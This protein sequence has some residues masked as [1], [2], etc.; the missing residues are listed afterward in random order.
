MEEKVSY[1]GKAGEWISAPLNW[2]GVIHAAR[3]GRQIMAE[4][5]Y[6]FIVTLPNSDRQP[7]KAVDCCLDTGCLI[8]ED[9]EGITVAAYAAGHWVRVQRVEEAAEEEV[10]IDCR[11]YHQ[12][13]KIARMDGS[14]NYW[15][16]TDGGETWEK[17]MTA[18]VKG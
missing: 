14:G 3:T 5:K 2:D 7:V 6:T 12:P 10:T 17:T 1:S 4:K 15:E 9:S 13:S 8:F 18:R 11:D 16:S